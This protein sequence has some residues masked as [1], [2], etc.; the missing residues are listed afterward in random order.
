MAE[1]LGRQPRASKYSADM[2]G[3]VSGKDEDMRS[4]AKAFWYRL[5]S[6]LTEEEFD[7]HNPQ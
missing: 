5:A 3:H 7:K 1:A 6:P 4:E 2:Y